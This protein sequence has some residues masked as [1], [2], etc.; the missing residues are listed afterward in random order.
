MKHTFPEKPGASNNGRSIASVLQ[1]SMLAVHTLILPQRVVQAS[2]TRAI[3]VPGGLRPL[4]CRMQTTFHDLPKRVPPITDIQITRQLGVRQVAF[5]SWSSG[6]SL[7]PRAVAQLLH[8]FISLGVDPRVPYAIGG[9]TSRMSVGLKLL[10]ATPETGDGD[11]KAEKKR[12]GAESEY[13]ERINPML[14]KRVDAQAS[15]DFQVDASPYGGSLTVLYGRDVFGKAF[16]PPLQSEWTGSGDPAD[17]TSSTAATK[18]ARGIRLELQGTV[19]LDLSPSWTLKGTRQVGDFTSIG[20]GVG[21]QGA[22]GLIVSVSWKRLGQNIDVPVAVCPAEILSK[23]AVMWALAVPWATYIAIDYGL[24]RTLARR[25]RKEDRARRRKELRKLLDKRKAEAGE[26]TSLMRDQVQRRQRRERNK[27][28]LVILK[29]EYGV[30]QTNFKGQPD[31]TSEN[32]WKPGEVTDVT[33]ALAA[34]VD[35]GQLDIPRQMVKVSSLRKWF[36]VFC[37]SI[38]VSNPRVLRPVAALP[39]SPP[40]TLLVC[41]Q[42]T[43]SHSGGWRASSLS[44]ANTRTE[45]IDIWPYFCR[46]LY[47]VPRAWVIISS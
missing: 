35:S 21:L 33:I 12:P 41:G 17:P 2:V 19:G 47:R 14:S 10:P 24:I 30:L 38:I 44:D 46:C 36:L 20:L 22:R 43:P 40:C 34:L 37:S 5:C 6:A 45:C 26:A 13:A 1:G 25:R 29:A 39:E 16:G 18:A 8:P 4:V 27:G 15:W 9:G 32:L 28:G 3:T 7:W 42:G 11:D 23:E 31:A